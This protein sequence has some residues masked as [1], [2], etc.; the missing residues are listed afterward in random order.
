M[1]DQQT[2]DERS[3]LLGFLRVG[4]RLMRR[5]WWGRERPGGEPTPRKEGFIGVGGRENL[6]IRGEGHRNLVIIPFTVS[7]TS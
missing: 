5:R 6:N 4:W 3:L 1:S 2:V 7:T